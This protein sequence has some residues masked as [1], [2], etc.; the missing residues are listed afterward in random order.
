MG[1]ECRWGELKS[2]AFDIINSLYNW[3][4]VQD[5]CIISSNVEQEVVCVLSKG[6]IANDLGD[7]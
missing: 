2:A 5:R 3:H 7:P 1:D 4:T 6:Y